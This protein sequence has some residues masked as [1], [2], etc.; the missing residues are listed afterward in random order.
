MDIGTLLGICSAFGLLGFAMLMLGASVSVFI[1][2]PSIFIVLGGSF[3]AVLAMFPLKTIAS[4]FKVMMKCFFYKLENPRALIEQIITLGEKARKESIIS[5]EKV[6]VSDPFMARGIQMVAD[7]TELSLLRKILDID[8]AIMQ[9]RH[10]RGQDVFKALGTAAPAFGMMGTLIG[11]VLML[12]QMDDPSNIGPA[13]AMALITTFYGTLLANCVCLPMA[14]KLEERSK[15]EVRNME[16]M[17]EGILSIQKG[18]HPYLIKEKLQSFLPHNMRE[19][20][21]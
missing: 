21:K 18:E 16:L 17:R 13:M 19:V 3:S 15:D 5:L 6:Q 7:G 11:L 20:R 12:R 14:K 8:M 2:I 9:Q 10:W 1:D 4:T